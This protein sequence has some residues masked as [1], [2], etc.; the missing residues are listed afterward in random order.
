[1]VDQ[2]YLMFFNLFFTS[3]PPLAMGTFLYIHWP[4]VDVMCVF[5]AILHAHTGIYDQSA[6]A[7][8]LLGQPPLYA[9]G[10]EAQLYRSHS[11]WVNII[12]A[13]YQSTVIFFIA[14]CVRTLTQIVVTR[15]HPF[16]L[17]NL[18]FIMMFFSFFCECCNI[19]GLRRHDGGS[20]GVW[21]ARYVI[22]HFGHADT[23]CI[24]IQIVGKQRSNVKE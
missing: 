11:F 24:G 2:I 8:M 13:L 16:L 6:P 21:H 18:F 14:Y 17:E 23:H 22:L 3:L 5:I 9:V 4:F 1:M 19:S 10:R 12:D 20:M 7:D 15:R